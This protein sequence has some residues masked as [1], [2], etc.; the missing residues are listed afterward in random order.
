M[1]PKPQ[2]APRM[3]EALRAGKRRES[4][5]AEIGA[6]A[7]G[8]PGPAAAPSPRGSAG[9]QQNEPQPGG[10]CP[11]RGGAAPAPGSE[12][13]FQPPNSKQTPSSS[14][15]KKKTPSSS[16]KKKKTPSSSSKKK[17]PPS[18]SEK[19][20][21]ANSFSLSP[22]VATPGG[23]RRS[24]RRCSL[25]GRR[26]RRKSL[27]PVHQDVAELSKSISLELPEI[28]RLSLLL[29]SS[30]QF[31]AQKL[32][33]VLEESEG[34]DPEAFAAKVQ[35]SSEEFQRLLQRLLQDGTLGNCLEQPPGDCL[36][37]ALEESVA[38]VKL[39]MASFSGE[40][41]AWDQLLQQHLQHSQE[42]SRTLEQLR[43]G[44]PPLGPSPIPKSQIVGFQ[45]RLRRD[46][47]PAG[48]GAA[49]PEAAGGRGPSGRGAGAGAAPGEP[50]FLRELS[51][52]MASRTFRKLPSSP[53]RRLLERKRRREPEPGRGI[54]TQIPNTHTWEIG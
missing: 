40:L 35:V 21:P 14:S 54:K 29:L 5:M 3:S 33:Q 27:P 42:A 11:E 12:E 53:A 52:H 34:F 30:F 46:P 49:V 17:K 9:P 8:S 39:L 37:P 28:Q 47:G 7:G 6:G 32:K 13:I 2:R 25:K 20:P 18:S 10:A 22:I 31:S 38:Q 24:W 45:T 15:R 19:E 51:G 26:S 23:R 50:D 44:L 4:A 41:Q 36:D 43:A 48:A 16:S 1:A